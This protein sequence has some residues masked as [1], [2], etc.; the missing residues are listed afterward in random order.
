MDRQIIRDLFK[1]CIAASEVLQ[2]D[3]AFRK[4][5][6]EKYKQIAP[7]Q[8]G[9]AGQLQEWMED[10]DDTADTHRHVSHLWGVYPGTDITWDNSPDMMRAA[11]K[12]FQYRGDDGT[13]WS[14]AWKV[15]LMARFKQGDHAM[16]L[17]NKLLSVA[18][19]GNAKERGGVY[20]NLFDAHPPFQIDGN[21]GGAAGI[22]EMLVQS[23]GE[24]IDLLPALPTA[25]A[26]GEIKGVCARGGFVLSIKWQ[27][28][29]LKQVQVTSSAGNECCLKYGELQHHFKT[30]KGKTYTFNGDFK[31]VL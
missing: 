23:Q 31:G 20:H 17:L 25:M 15:N 29:K 9:R 18:E 26:E 1:N 7:N 24:Y 28:G 19:N 8:I 11:E 30:I 12:S 6:Q 14:L 4:I 5:L 27:N 10:K 21:F 2:T 22:A 3:V 16:L 13:G